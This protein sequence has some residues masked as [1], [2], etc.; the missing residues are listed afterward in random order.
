MVSFGVVHGDSFAYLAVRRWEPTGSV[1]RPRVR[2]SRRAGSDRDRRADPELGPAGA[3]RIG[4]HVLPTGLPAVTAPRC[5][6]AS[7]SWGKRRGV[8]TLSW[9]PDQDDLVGS[10][11]NPSTHSAA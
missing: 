3:K 4:T 8:V 2:G 7:P 9:R 11:L 10:A 6:L 5:P 1:R